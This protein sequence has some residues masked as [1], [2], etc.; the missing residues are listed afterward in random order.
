MCEGFASAVDPPFSEG[1][2]LLFERL[3]ALPEGRRTLVAIA[4]APGSGKSTLADEVVI[5]LND[6]EGRK[7]AVLPMDGYHFDD[8][9]LRALGLLERK[10]APDTFDVSGLW[11]MLRRLKDN[12]EEAVAVPVFD[13]EL[14]IA[15]GAARLIPQS[16]DIIVVEGNYLLSD[17]QPWASLAPLFDLTVLLDVPEPVLRQRLVGRWRE[18]GHSGSEALARAEGNDLPNGRYVREK[19][20]APDIVL[21]SAA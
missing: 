16:T 13:R 4:G 5:R 7:A 11:H 14:E 10:G 15:R 19:S 20:H 9:L 2:E 3:L 1:V 8:G 12:T 17:E 21:R 18:H 6:D